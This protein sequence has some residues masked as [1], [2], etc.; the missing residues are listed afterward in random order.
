[1]T[2]IDKYEG[3]PGK[4]PG[5]LLVQIGVSRIYFSSTLQADMRDFLNTSNGM[6]RPGSIANGSTDLEP[7]PTPLG[8]HTVSALAVG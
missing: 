6:S 5:F 1:M 2:E 7:P 8:G 3:L 4:T